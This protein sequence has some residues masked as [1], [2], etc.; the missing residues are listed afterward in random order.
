M[1]RS[2]LASQR[3]RSVFGSKKYAQIELGGAV[4]AITG[5]ARGIGRATAVEFLKRGSTV[6]LG[7]VDLDAAERTAAELGGKA[8]A[9]HV[10]VSDKESFAEF[11]AFAEA[12]G[13]VRVLVNNAGIMPIGDYLEQPEGV[14]RAMVDVN[15]WGVSNGMRLALPAM[16]ERGQGHVV[17]VSSMAAKLHGAGVAMYCA[18]KWAVLALGLSVR[19]ELA[20]TGVTISTVLPAAIATDLAAGIPGPLGSFGVAAVLRPPEEVARAVV[21]S[22]DSRAAEIPVPSVLRA[23]DAVLAL[24]PELVQR[25]VRGLA[26]FGPDTVLNKADPEMRADYN[27]RIDEQAALRSDR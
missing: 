21:R 19:E 1:A 2:P 13:E 24:T 9:T 11:L 22:V 6:V 17:N 23:T 8:H 26:G 12:L 5:G 18:S 3:P 7:D 10:D 25:R 15:L 16:I 4:V 27:A 20:G 14:L